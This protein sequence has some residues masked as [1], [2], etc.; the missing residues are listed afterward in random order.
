MFPVL[1][2]LGTWDLP[3]IG[4]TPIFLPTYGVLFATSV[5][6][7]WW[8]FARRGRELGIDP[9]RQFNLAFYAVLAGLIGAKA[10]LIALDWRLYLANPRLILGTLRSAGVLV[11]GVTGGALAFVWYSRR[12]GLPTWRLADALAAPLALAQGIGRLG[13]LAAGCC[14]GR[15]VSADNPLAIVFTDPRAGAQTGV[16]LHTPLV[17]TQAIQM[18]ADVALAGVLTLLWR[19]RPEPPGTVFWSYVLFYSV[20]RG[21]IEFWRGDVARGLWLGGAV[22]TSQLFALGGIVVACTVLLVGRRRRRASD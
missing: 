2:D 3:F 20:V 14:W 18:V 15:A 16:P 7:C 21:V 13:C 12:Y 19:R 10:L 1:I 17:A 11:G 22:S 9:E 5:V 6:V 8:W 4:E